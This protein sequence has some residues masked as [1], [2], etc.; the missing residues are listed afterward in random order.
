MGVTQR[1]AYVTRPDATPEAEL[2]ALA[3]VYSLSLQKHRENQR[4]AKN[5]QPGG[6]DDVRKDLDAH[7]AT[8]NH[9]R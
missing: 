7:T 1:I 8:T 6:S 3:S 9:N 2:D 4:A 5:S